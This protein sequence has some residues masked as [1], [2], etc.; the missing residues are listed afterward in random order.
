VLLRKMGGWD[1]SGLTCA[2]AAAAAAAAIV[3]TP[4]YVCVCVCLLTCVRKPPPPCV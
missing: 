4:V 3:R 1:P 2:P